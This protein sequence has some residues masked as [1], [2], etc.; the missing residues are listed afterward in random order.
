MGCSSSTP[1]EPTEA[2]L[3]AERHEAVI[4]EA[5]QRYEHELS[6]LRAEIAQAKEAYRSELADETN[7]RMGHIEVRRLLSHMPPM[8][9]SLSHTRSRFFVYAAIEKGSHLPAAD[10]RRSRGPIRTIAPTDAGRDGAFACE[11]A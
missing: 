3:E 1:Y 2:E 8:R 7:R 6:T 4:L 5:M 9:H 10:C 11:A